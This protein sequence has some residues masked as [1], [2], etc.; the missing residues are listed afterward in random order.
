MRNPFA[1]SNAT[2]DY[3]I[4]AFAPNGYDE[5]SFLP[6]NEPASCED[7]TGDQAYIISGVS[8]ADVWLD[9]V[10]RT[11]DGREWVSAGRTEVPPRS[12]SSCVVLHDQSIV[13]TAGLDRPYPSRNGFTQEALNDVWRS[14]SLGTDWKLVTAAAAFPARSKTLM[15]AAPTPLRSDH[16]VIFVM[17]GKS[18]QEGNVFYNDVVRALPSA[19]SAPLSFA[20]LRALS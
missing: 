17:G 10:W 5:K 7:P 4:I 14:T 2:R 9:D 13:V 3:E 6:R 16:D 20:G 12:R 8:R 15:F 1:Y 19:T 18:Q 11:D